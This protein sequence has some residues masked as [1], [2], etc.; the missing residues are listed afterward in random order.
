MMVGCFAQFVEEGCV[1][2]SLLLCLFVLSAFPF[3]SLMFF[4]LFVFPVFVVIRG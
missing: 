2:L 4:A 1:F 3:L